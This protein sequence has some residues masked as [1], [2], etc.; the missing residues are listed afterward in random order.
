[1][2]DYFLDMIVF[3][4]QFDSGWVVVI[5]FGIKGIVCCG[6]WDSMVV[7]V[8]CWENGFRVGV[9]YSFFD[10]F[11]CYEFIWVGSIKVRQFCIMERYFL[12]LII[13]DVQRRFLNLNICINILVL[14]VREVY[15][16]L[17]V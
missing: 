13:V 1:M 5:Q 16:G 10:E 8:F 17:C 15:K 4:E 9:V 7:L 14:G 11:M 3:I 6:G 2:C 12:F